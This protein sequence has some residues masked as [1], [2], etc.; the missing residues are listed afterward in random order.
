MRGLA[1]LAAAAEL[2][3][4]CVESF[5]VEPRRSVSH[6]RP[7]AKTT[8]ARTM[9][10]FRRWDTAQAVRDA[11][12]LSPQW[13]RRIA[14]YTALHGELITEFD[15]VFGLSAEP[16][17][18]FAESGQQVPQPVIEQVL[19]QHVRDSG[20]VDLR[21][22]ERVVDVR[23]GADTVTC[24]I[25]RDDNTTYRLEADHVLGCDGAGSVVRKRMGATLQGCSATSSSLN[26]VFRSMSLHPTAGAALHY[27]I[28]GEQVQGAIGAGFPGKGSSYLRG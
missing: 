23:E 10:I 9:E 5:V 3:H 8:S 28:P 26:I 6:D 11:A 18:V 22:G 14:I 13:S 12:P 1:G 20:L 16:S 2:A 19:R 24:L 21:V 25:E 7:R 17:D 27:W 15:D 4:H